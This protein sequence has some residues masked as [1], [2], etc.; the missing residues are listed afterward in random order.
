VQLR[1]EDAL[2]SRD[3]VAAQC[4]RAAIN[5][6]TYSSKTA[7]NGPSARIGDFHNNIGPEPKKSTHEGKAAVEVNSAR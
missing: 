7:S 4:E 1:P 5:A 2:V 6:L 3:E